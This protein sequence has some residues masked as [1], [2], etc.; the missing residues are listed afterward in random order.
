MA[1][2]FHLPKA[3]RFEYKPLYYNEI[4]EQRKER[5]A[6]ILKEIEAEKQG[7][8]VALTKEELDNYIRLSRKAHKKSN[9]RL[10]II[11]ALLTVLFYYLFYY[12]K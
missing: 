4:T 8:K 7:K 11:L 9:K 5:N 12:T 6:A 3:K 10:L 1:K 2:F